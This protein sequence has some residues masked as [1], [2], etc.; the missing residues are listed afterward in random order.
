[1]PDDQ[2]LACVVCTCGGEDNDQMNPLTSCSLIALVCEVALSE[3]FTMPARH[4]HLHLYLQS[5][6]VCTTRLGR[7]QFT[8][9]MTSSTSGSPE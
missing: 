3:L 1:M 5:F 9:H 7:R 2:V 4:H 8:L 6:T